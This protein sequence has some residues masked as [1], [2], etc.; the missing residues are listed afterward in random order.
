[1]DFI[2]FDYVKY[3]GIL[4]IL[5]ICIWLLVATI[6]KFSQSKAR[7]SANSHDIFNSKTSSLFIQE[8]L[9]VD[10]KTKII[11]VGR[12]N[13]RHVILLSETHSTLIET[14]TP[15][16]EETAKPVNENPF[17]PQEQAFRVAPD[18]QPAPEPDFSNI[19]SEA[20]DD[21][22]VLTSNIDTSNINTSNVD[23][24]ADKNSLENIAE[25]LDNAK[26][27]TDNKA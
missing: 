11:I 12:D 23:A 10:Q 17:K 22:P 6:K 8:V 3:F 27:I 21:A 24:K 18:I 26:K 2:N 25:K 15:P 4:I 20:I 16:S 13:L 9:P 14:V 1:M 5:V 7:N 19:R